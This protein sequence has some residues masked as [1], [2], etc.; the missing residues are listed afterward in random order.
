MKIHLLSD[1]HI[2]SY[3]KRQLPMG[4]LP[5]TD[6]DIVILAGDISNSS[7]G[8]HWSIAQSKKINLPIL[9]IAGNHEYF[10]ENILTFDHQLNTLC[11]DTNVT[12]LQQK[13]Y[14][15]KG[16]RFLGCTLWTDFCYQID[17]PFANLPNIDHK[18]ARLELIQTQMRDYQGIYEG[19]GLLTI[20]HVKSINQQH[21]Q[22]LKN[23]LQTAYQQQI[24]TVV[25]SHHGI[26]PRSISEKYQDSPIN[27]SFI[28]D[29]TSW[30]H[31]KWA[32]ALWL[33]GHTHDAF[34]YI[35]GNTRVI[36]NPRAYPKET[37]S[38]AVAFDWHKVVDMK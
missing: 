34:D 3:Q 29:M 25:I 15:F 24:P 28:S 14:D 38:T 10:D 16:V 35:E 12:F 23:A 4:D 5:K 11:A 6:A 2:D 33:H 27:A 36:V 37:S 21:Q 1:L 26:S 8:M 17:K 31:Q 13:A 30:L 18:N 7:L 9:Y 22:W 20:E 19:S 32:P